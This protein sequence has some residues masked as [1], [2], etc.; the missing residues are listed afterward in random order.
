VDGHTKAKM[1]NV[2]TE[3]GMVEVLPGVSTGDTGAAADFSEATSQK[4]FPVA[5]MICFWSFFSFF[6]YVICA[7]KTLTYYVNKVFKKKK[8]YYLILNI[9]LIHWSTAFLQ[10]LN[11]V[12]LLEF[13]CFT[14]FSL[15]ASF[16]TKNFIFAKVFI[17]TFVIFVTFRMLFFRKK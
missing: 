10:L 17:K 16:F 7:C 11:F 8:F 3:A 5:I 6:C 12:C 14:A 1:A 15:P 9:T 2:D 13:G 4:K